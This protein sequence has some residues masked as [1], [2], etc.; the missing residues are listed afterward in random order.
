MEKV[1]PGSRLSR[2]G[3]LWRSFRHLPGFERLSL[4]LNEWKL[5]RTGPLVALPKA[6]SV[7]TLLS[8]LVRW[9]TYPPDYCCVKR[10]CL[11]QIA[12]RSPL[13]CREECWHIFVTG[14]IDLH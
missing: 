4:V 8:S 1:F 14:P 9:E 11:G 12:R 5:T 7:S 6:F 13:P 10:A 2:P 3:M